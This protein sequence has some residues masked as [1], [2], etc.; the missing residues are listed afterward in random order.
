[1]N[2]SFE[3]LLER[4]SPVDVVPAK[5]VQWLPA[6]VAHA[7]AAV[8]PC[9]LKAAAVMLDRLWSVVPMPSDDAL[10]VWIETA[11]KYPADLVRQAI[12]RIIETRTWERDP[13]LPGQLVIG[14]RDDLAVRTTK[15]NRLRVMRDMAGAGKVEP[16][17]KPMTDEQRDRISARLAAL[18][19]MVAGGNSMP[20]HPDEVMTGETKAEA[21]EQSLERS[22]RDA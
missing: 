20:L 4:W 1:M 22:G 5:A 7:D 18:R 19:S 14:L 16:E 17:R 21:R 3:R 10:R 13:P 12:D 9:G 11:A 8:E 15:R 6:A 2:A